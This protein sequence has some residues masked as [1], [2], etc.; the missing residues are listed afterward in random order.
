MMADPAWEVLHRDK[1]SVVV[2]KVPSGMAA[3]HDG[4]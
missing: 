3:D 1:V 4:R 2:R